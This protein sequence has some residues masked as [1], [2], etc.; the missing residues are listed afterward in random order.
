[1]PGTLTNVTPEME[2]PTMPKATIYHGDWR[3]PLKKVSLS[4]FLAVSLLKSSKARK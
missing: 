2:A 1:M 4:D 3:F